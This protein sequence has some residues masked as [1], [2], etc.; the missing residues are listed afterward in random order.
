M[1]F[2][3]ESSI[4]L[5]G[6]NF[7]LKERLLPCKDYILF[8][9]FSSHLPHLFSLQSSSVF[10][11]SLQA[12]FGYNLCM[13]ISIDRLVRSRRK[14][15]A[16]VIE[17][18]GNLTVRVPLKMAEVRIR[19]FVE[20]H[21]DWINKNQAK[22]RGSLPVSP[23]RYVEGE[24]FLYLGKSYP[25][26]IVPRQRSALTFTG[27]A[28]RMA[29]SASPKAAEFFL[30]WYKEQATLLLFE[31]VLTLAKEHGFKYQKLRI[32]S[33]RTRWGSCSSLGTLSFT[34]RLVMAPPQVVD[35]VVLHE[36]VHTQI[37]NHSKTFW[38]TLAE[39]MPDY[40]QRLAWLKKN[41]KYLM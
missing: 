23:K 36:L 10:L 24:K 41:G 7:L 8:F 15:I 38:N 37:R 39:L 16:L 1:P 32:S 2:Q 13:S 17:R 34:Y 29:K 12:A 31:R 18:D 27:E 5:P 4:A 35:Y 6:S 25:L 20:T 14:T 30:R 11:A 3:S 28:F 33:A 19:A 9:R 22:V 21:A 40:K 26:T